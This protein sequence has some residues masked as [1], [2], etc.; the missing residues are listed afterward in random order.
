MTSRNAAFFD[1]DDTL[2]N[3]NS[4]SCFGRYLYREGVLSTKLYLQLG[5]IYLL[6]KI[7]RLSLV[8]MQA[9]IFQRLFQGKPAAFF[10]THVQRFLD[11]NFDQ[12][13][14]LPAV[15]RLKQAQS[16][17]DLVAIL[18]S[19]PDF[20]VKPIAEKFHVN[21]WQASI[22]AVDQQGCFSHLEKLFQ[23]SDK[24]DWVEAF[25]KEWN[26]PKHNRT[27]FTDS[28]LDL[29]FLKAGGIR[30]GVNPDRQLRALCL[31]NHW[32]IL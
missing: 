18:S 9:R 24:A 23:G 1:L 2:L 16:N 7:G 5:A 29:P 32:E 17:G 10:Q 30:I 31:Q 11:Q 4:S 19:S 14:Y 8:K 15:E 12:L 6:F 25:A 20:L 22:Y 21:H 3:V 27:V 28:I 13:L 26:L